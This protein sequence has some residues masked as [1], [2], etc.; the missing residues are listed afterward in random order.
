M[1]RSLLFLAAVMV[2]GVALAQPAA[3]LAVTIVD[4]TP[5]LATGDTAQIQF[6][7]RNGGPD[8]ARNVRVFV[9]PDPRWIRPSLLITPFCTSLDCPIGD[10]AAGQQAPVRLY[11]TAPATAGDLT[12]ALRATSS[13]PDPRPENDSA[14]VTIP[15]VIEPELDLDFRRD[16]IYQAEGRGYLSVNVENRGRATATNVIVTIIMP[17]GSKILSVGG[18]PFQ[19]TAGFDTAVCH[20][21]SVPLTREAI[22]ISVRFVNPPFYDGAV[23]YASA[24]VTANE[25]EIELRN[26][27]TETGWRIPQLFT[28]TTTADAGP[29]SLRDAIVRANSGCASPCN[30]GFRIPGP[31]PESGFFTIRPET[32]L[33]M[34]RFPGNILGTTE[35]DLFD[36]DAKTPLVM[37]DGSNLTDADGLHLKA[38][39]GVSGIAIGNFPRFGIF[40]DEPVPYFGTHL[41]GVY[42]GVDP[43]GHTAA[44]NLR[45]VVVTDS[46]TL[47]V[48]NSVVSANRRSGIVGGGDAY[49][50]NNRIGVAADSDAPMPNGA[51]GIYLPGKGLT[52]VT[53]NVIAWNHD[54]AIALNPEQH[55]VILST[56][57]IHDN[58]G[59]IDYGLDGRTP[60]AANDSLRPPNFP[61]VDDAVYDPVKNK[62]IVT[63]HHN[64][65]P[66]PLQRPDREYGSI[67][68]KID[69]YAN[70]GP[71]AQAQRYLTTAEAFGGNTVR[72]EIAGDLRGQWITAVLIRRREDCRYEE[73]NFLVETSEIGPPH[74]VR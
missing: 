24:L 48:A 73:C 23:V 32:P 53:N 54:V 39:M 52:M 43:S 74:D 69:L 47:S 11:V 14:R 8:T 42:L 38:G 34:A 58:G 66:A 19:C 71:N 3:D 15:V 57:S 18:D 17:M 31:L 7:V 68:F 60:N 59:G 27:V 36:F 4:V 2:A 40:A 45:G 56:S 10:L 37:L 41:D 61:T 63:A 35:T 1:K 67:S 20:A 12:A 33:P 46:M 21:A 26:N 16:Y 62:T 5:A 25:P 30:V 70:D 6:V 44:P 50:D 9:T 29:G 64:S 22:P 13:T 65:I 28:V 49:L 51:S 72:A 55:Y